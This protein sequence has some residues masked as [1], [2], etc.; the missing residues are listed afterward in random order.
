MEK[1]LTESSP[2]EKRDA[3]L[4]RWLSPPNAQF[5]NAECE[6]LYKQRV[7][8]LE[9]AIRLTEPDRVPVMLPTAN[10][11]IYFSGSTL[12]KAMYDY[13]EIRRTWLNFLKEFDSD[14]YGSPF[15]VLPGKVFENLDYRLYKWPGHGLGAD[16]A[17]YQCVER[18]YMKAEEYDDLIY[19]PSDFWFRVYL[20][21][22]F[23]AFEPFRK[24]A[25]FTTLAEVPIAYFLP[26]TMPDI[27][28]SLQKLIDVGR[29]TGKWFGVIRYCDQQ[30]LSA[31]FPSLRGG[32]AA[33]APFDTIGDT[34]RGT[35]GIMTDMYRRPQKLLEAMERLTFLTI[36]TTVSAANVSGDRFVLMPLHKGSDGFMSLDQFKTFYWPTLKNVIL[37]LIQEG[38]IPLVFAEGC[39]D[40]RLEIVKDLPKGSVIWWFDQTDMGKAK[41]VLGSDFCLAGNIPTSLLCAGTPREVNDYCRQLIGV[42]G[43]G[44][45]FIL[46]GGALIDRGNPDNLR[47]MMEATKEYGTYPRSK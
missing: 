40:S 12:Q 46:T 44:G 3:R 21:R 8:R 26:F 28:D 7:M 20:P 1:G 11:P 6:K 37:G 9:A 32:A 27:Q 4:K 41:Q 43:K 16:V 33:K 10:F 14:T 29:E 17:S 15:L 2:D 36:K 45:G 13:D 5:F 22:V 19:D 31:G 24:M 18:E 35:Q 38:L 47:A 42:A 25:A 34:L 23:G 30:A 39:Y